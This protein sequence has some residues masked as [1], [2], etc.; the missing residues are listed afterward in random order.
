MDEQQ[1]EAIYAEILKTV[2]KNMGS[3]TT[4]S[5]ELNTL[6]KRLF[7]DKWAGVFA[8]DQIPKM[9]QGQYAITNLDNSNQKGSHW[10]GMIKTGNADLMIYDS[11][12][13]KSKKILPEVVS[14]GNGKVHNTDPDAEQK[15]HEKTCGQ[16]S[17]AWI[18]LHH[19]F[20]HKA[21]MHI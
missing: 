13:R 9:K 3:K 10:V 14:S 21:S 2:I 8:S 6:G 5:T 17:I 15:K 12:G 16:R 20:G 18:L 19:Y 7:K 4:W 11:F 1:A